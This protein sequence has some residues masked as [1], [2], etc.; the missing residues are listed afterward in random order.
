MGCIS[1]DALEKGMVLSE[2]VLDINAR[3]L[4]S[5]GQQI[6]PKH[7]RILKVWGIINVNI[8]GDKDQKDHQEAAVDPQIIE[9]VQASTKDIFKNIDLAHPAIE[10]I[11]KLS[12]SYRSQN[13]R[14]DTKTNQRLKVIG[15]LD[16]NARLNIREKIKSLNIR[17]PEIPSIVNELNAITA[18]PYASA[19]DIAEIVNKS[20]SLTAILL[21]IVNSAFY[22]FPAKIDTV[23]RAVTLI[24]S[25]EITGLAL[26]LSTMQVFKDVPEDIMDMKAFL[27]HSLLCGLISRIIASQRNMPQTEQMFV[28]GLLHDIGR[29]IIYKYFPDQANTIFNNA[30]ESNQSLYSME[31]DIIGCRHADIG[32][33]LLKNYRLSHALESNVSYHHRPSQAADPLETGIIHIADIISNGLGIGSSGEKIIPH[34]DDLIWE[35]LHISPQLFK[36]TVDLAVHQLASLEMFFKRID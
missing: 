16:H 10:E 5:K 32:K 31:K 2:D 21:K 30:L 29:L 9:A 24:G 35:D 14:S 7:I 12:V 3:L 36:P 11:F 4:L 8:V 27:R 15:N 33:W 22:S 26:G 20:P 34:F 1:V 19:N 23:S 6:T 25:K 13:H 28:S 18:D 17:L